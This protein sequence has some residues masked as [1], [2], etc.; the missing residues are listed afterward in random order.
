M[1]IVGGVGE[2]GDANEALLMETA[3]FI[4]N[5]LAFAYPLYEWIISFQGGSLV[6]RTTAI[7]SHYGMVIN[8]W[9]SASELKKKAIMFAGELLERARLSRDMWDGQYAKKL[10]GGKMWGNQCSVQ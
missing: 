2:H 4:G 8:D 7:K 1:S 10:E 5:A 9:Y 3:K 6:I